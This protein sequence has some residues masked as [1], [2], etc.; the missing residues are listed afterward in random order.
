MESNESERVRKTTSSL[1]RFKRHSERL[2]I[3]NSGNNAVVID[4]KT[5]AIGTIGTKMTFQD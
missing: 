3:W 2:R 1:K 4:L 5:E